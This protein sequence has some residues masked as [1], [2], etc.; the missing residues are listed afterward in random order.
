LAYAFQNINL[1]VT[2]EKAG[3]NIDFLVSLGVCQVLELEV[4][5]DDD[6]VGVDDNNGNGGSNF[7]LGDGTNPGQGVD[8]DNAGGIS[9]GEGMENPANQV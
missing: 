9:G 6:D 4:E 1:L 5:G 3:K 2:P 8:N 7:G